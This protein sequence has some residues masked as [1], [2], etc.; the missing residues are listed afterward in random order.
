[1][2]NPPAP[3]STQRHKQLKISQ[4]WVHGQAE[5]RSATGGAAQEPPQSKESSIN[6]RQI[7]PRKKTKKQAGKIAKSTSKYSFPTL[8]ELT[9]SKRKMYNKYPSRKMTKKWT[10][11]TPKNAPPPSMGIT[12][13]KQRKFKK[14][15]IKCA[16]ER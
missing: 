12:A 13:P 6:G 15:I 7:P 3:C 16:P 9:T 14:W 1:M 2:T 10:G 4:K 5:T 8:W 11:K